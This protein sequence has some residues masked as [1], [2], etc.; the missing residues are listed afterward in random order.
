M[1]RNILNSKLESY[2]PNKSLLIYGLLGVIL[3]KIWKFLIIHLIPFPNP[4]LRYYLEQTFFTLYRL[5]ISIG[6]AYLLSK[7]FVN[8][9]NEWKIGGDRYFKTNFFI[10]IPLWFFIHIFL[11][12][13]T[14][15]QT[16]FIWELFFNIFTGSFEEIFFRGLILVGFSQYISPRKSLILSSLL[17]SIWHFDVFS[18]PADYLASFLFG[19]YLGLCY[20][21]GTT[22]LSLILVHFLWD[23]VVF[24]FNW[25]KFSGLDTAGT[26]NLIIMVDIF[27]ICSLLVV[28]FRKDLFEKNI[29]P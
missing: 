10:L 5:F 2:I 16:Q 27:L 1:E 22:L 23:Q 20:L 24:G 26:N 3:Y 12:G 17:F 13:F 19:M 8:F 4:T 15:D 21:H 11:L 9:K 6:G 25:G 7:Y 29:K 28:N 14:P 18:N